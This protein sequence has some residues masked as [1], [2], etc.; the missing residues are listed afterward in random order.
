MAKKKKKDECA[1]LEDYSPTNIL[2]S[3]HVELN[4][5]IDIGYFSLEIERNLGCKYLGE[6]EIKGWYKFEVPQGCEEEYIKKFKSFQQVTYVEKRDLRREK[7]HEELKNIEGL[8]SDIREDDIQDGPLS[9]KE[10]Q[11]RLEIIALEAR[12]FEDTIIDKEAL[13]L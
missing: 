7:R 1:K 8:I 12:S 6:S 10:I 3:L 11:E 13:D 4:T 2:G 5:G 9:L